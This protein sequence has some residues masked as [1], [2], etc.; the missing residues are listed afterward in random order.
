MRTLSKR[1]S[2]KAEPWSEPWL[3]LFSCC[4]VEAELPVRYAHMRREWA[5]VRD[6]ARN[7]RELSLGEAGTAVAFGAECFAWFCVGE[8]VGRGGTLTGYDY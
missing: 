7:W 4:S 6:A 1:A 2:Q 8:I 5:A 3:T